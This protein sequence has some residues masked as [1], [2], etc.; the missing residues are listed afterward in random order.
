MQV[1]LTNKG[2]IASKRNAQFIFSVSI[3]GEAPKSISK[4]LPKIDPGQTVVVSLQDVGVLQ[5]GA[6]VDVSM[7]PAKRTTEPDLT[8]N[9]RREEIPL[10]MGEYEAILQNPK[11]S[12]SIIWN[13]GGISIS[14]PGWTNEQKN[15][16]ADAIRRRENGDLPLLDGPPEV[17]TLEEP[18]ISRDDAWKIFLSFVA[19]SLWVEKNQLVPW[20][21]ANMSES[22]LRL[23]F[24]SGK[25]FWPS[26]RIALSEWQY[27]ADEATFY[28]RMHGGSL[29]I[30]RAHV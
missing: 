29:E 6:V 28:T 8:N 13:N 18:T 3:N 14:Y 7:R 20:S 19:Q 1:A 23:L 26:E 17:R 30:G 25:I 21:L 10:S 5:K 12:S 2:G 4:E 22:E 11:I 16:L 27:P 24:D 15:Q 9:T